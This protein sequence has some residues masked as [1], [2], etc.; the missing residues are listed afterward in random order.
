M[1][2]YDLAVK[3][4]HNQVTPALGCTEPG[5][6]ALAVARAKQILGEEVSKLDVTVDKNILKNGMGVGIPGT[7]GIGIV[8]ASALALVCGKPELGLEVLAGITP[9]D[10]AKANELIGKKVVNLVLD[11]QANG[12]TIV[13]DAHGRSRSSRVII[14]NTH[15]NI[16]LE[17][18]EGDILLDKRVDSGGA[19][20]PELRSRIMEFDID[21]LYNVADTVDYSEIAFIKDGITMNKRIAE[22]GISNDLGIGMGRFFMSRAKTPS[23]RAKALTAAASEARMAG[24]PLPVMSSAG[25]GNHGLVAILPIAIIGESLGCTEEHIVRAVTLSHLVTVFVKAQLGSLSPVCGCGVAAGVGCAAGLVYLKGGSSEQVRCA[26]D[27]TIAG[28]AGMLCDGAKLGCSYKLSIA[29]DSSVDAADMALNGLKIPSFNGILGNTA[30]E[31]VANLARVS[32][33]GMNNTDSVILNVMLE[34]SR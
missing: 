22:A 29:V 23:E 24:W 19:Q 27:N 4:L 12:L 28:I 9:D 25:S 2:N 26:I 15:T 20:Q 13:V 10:I 31:S 3:I 7:D 11:E 16:V 14:K 6:V 1:L 32:L 21:D 33:K 18:V 8:F 30:E 5:A 17:S 34:K